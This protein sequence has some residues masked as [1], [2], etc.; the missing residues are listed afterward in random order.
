MDCGVNT[1]LH[2]TYMILVSMFRP[3][4]DQDHSPEDSERIWNN[5]LLKILSKILEFFGGMLS[6]DSRLILRTW[7]YS[8]IMEIKFI[9]TARKLRYSYHCQYGHYRTNGIQ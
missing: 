5:P 7:T 3:G 8:I 9:L 2:M 1:V 6:H 4:I